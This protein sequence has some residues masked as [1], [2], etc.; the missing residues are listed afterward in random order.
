MPSR[1][2]VV[3]VEEARVRGIECLVSPGVDKDPRLLADVASP[4]SV[5]VDNGSN[6]NV[7]MCCWDA[8]PV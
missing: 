8:V 1:I 7:A 2:S 4:A 5:T 3:L 6:N